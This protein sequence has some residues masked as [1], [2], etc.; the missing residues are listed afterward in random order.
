MDRSATLSVAG[1]GARVVTCPTLCRTGLSAERARWPATTMVRAL[2][3]VDR[4][5]W[6]LDP[7]VP[8]LADRLRWAQQR[9]VDPALRVVERLVARNDVA[10]D[11][12]ANQGL[13]TSHLLGVVG[14]RGSVHAFEPNPIH[15]PRLRRLGRGNPQLTIHSLA[16][17]DGAG[18][19]QLRVPIVEGVAQPGVASLETRSLAADDYQLVAARRDRLDD[20]L[21]DLS[22]LNFIKCDVEGHEQAV[23]DGARG[24]LERHRPAVLV[25]IEQRH[26]SIAPAATFALME[27]V[28]YAGFC[29]FPSGLRPLTE[30]DLER[31][32]L[33]FINSVGFQGK[34]PDGYVH[35]FVFVSDA[36]SL[37]SV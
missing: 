9:R 16:L 34:M 7:M 14:S 32:Q 31:D 5:A 37:T 1:T 36:K 6:H 35:D 24:L 20:V 33:Q 23:L 13:F 2:A 30:F 3:M 28:G 22:R 15:H 12:G 27:E 29:V 19:A 25:E 11:I 26:R 21:G 10:L 8:R 18:D 17:S 4:L